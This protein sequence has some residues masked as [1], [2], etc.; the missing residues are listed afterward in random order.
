MKIY[1]LKLSHAGKMNHQMIMNGVT[2]PEVIMLKAVHGPQA[3]E[4]LLVT[5]HAPGLNHLEEKT[6]LIDKYGQ[7]KFEE[8]FP[9]FS[10]ILPADLAQVGI[11]AEYDGRDL[12][13]QKVGQAVAAA[14][15][16]V[17]AAPVIE[18]PA[19]PV[20]EAPVE[21]PAEGDVTGED[22]GRFKIPGKNK[23]KG[24]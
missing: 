16:P 5:G 19:A 7:K 21:A 8:M 11:E 1:Q 13:V 9:G 6:R 2:A 4:D 20:I 18:A 24:L 15:A 12:P 17:A 3:V 23:A 14:A 22:F 10:P